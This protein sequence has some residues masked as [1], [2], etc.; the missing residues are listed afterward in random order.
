MRDGRVHVWL[1]SDE[2]DEVVRKYF[3]LLSVLHVAYV[4][5]LVEVSRTPA[6]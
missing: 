2:D 5:A 4:P 6:R 1:G 3:T